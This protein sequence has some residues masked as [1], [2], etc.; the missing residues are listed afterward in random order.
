MSEREKNRNGL[1]SKREFIGLRFRHHRLRLKPLYTNKAGKLRLVGNLVILSILL[2]M[3]ALGILFIVEAKAEQG[4]HD[5]YN[6]TIGLRKIYNNVVNTA[7]LKD[8]RVCACQPNQVERYALY[9]GFKTTI[10]IYDRGGPGLRPGIVLIHGNVWNG[11]KLST[12]RVVA[13]K[14]AEK[15]FIVLSFD[16]VGFGES[17][18]P[19]GQG[20]TAVAAAYDKV[21]QVKKAV[22]YLVVHKNVDPD[23]ITLLGHSGGTTEALIVGQ[24]SNQIANVVIWVAP[25]APAANESEAA[26]NLSYLDGK[27]QARYE[28]LYGR[29]IPDWF[30]WSMTGVEDQDSDEIWEYYR[31]KGHKPLILVLGENDQPDAH[32][33]VLDTYETLLEPKSL[34]FVKSA[35]HYLNTAQSLQWVFYNQK[36]VDELVNGLVLRLSK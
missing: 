13:H 5:P 19:F 12:Y 4:L 30:E 14:L 25:S 26:A 8:I 23:N 16:Q 9:N 22:E 20:P 3:A 10:S 17:D 31:Q 1:G 7:D 18:D 15:G 33:Y 34:L 29:K 36:I 21:S 24:Q 11:Q 35:D 2:V 6:R 28:L 32:S 27:F